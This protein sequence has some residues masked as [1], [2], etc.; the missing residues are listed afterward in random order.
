MTTGNP[1]VEE[2]TETL[3]DAGYKVKTTDAPAI[4]RTSAA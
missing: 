1:T 3:E 4:R 2:A